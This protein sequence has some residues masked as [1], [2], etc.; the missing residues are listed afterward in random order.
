VSAGLG[1]AGS[2]TVV[3]LLSGDRSE[4]VDGFVRAFVV[5]PGD[6]VQDCWLEVAPVA[7]GPVRLDQLGLEQADDRLGEGVIPRRQLRPFASL[8]S[9]WCG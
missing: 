6:P 1:E 3:Q 4:V 9:K 8:R 7:P 5:E 2:V